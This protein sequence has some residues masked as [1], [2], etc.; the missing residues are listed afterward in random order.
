MSNYLEDAWVFV[1]SKIALF[2]LWLLQKPIRLA[3][4]QENKQHKGVS[5]R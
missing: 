5:R 4:E 1:T 3:I 2:F